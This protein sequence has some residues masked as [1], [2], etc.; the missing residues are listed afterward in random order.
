MSV[1]DSVVPEPAVKAG[2]KVKSVSR[3]AIIVSAMP[4]SEIRSGNDVPK[5]SAT[6][7]PGSATPSFDALTRR[8][9]S[10]SLAAKVR[11]AGETEYSMACAPPAPSISMGIVTWRS[12]TALNVMGRSTCAP[13]A[14]R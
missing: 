9:L 5:P 8:V 14:T 7:S 4:P 11:L 6:L 10:V 3:I 12:G 1:S 13:S 2:A